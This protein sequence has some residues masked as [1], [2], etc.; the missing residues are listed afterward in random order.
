MVT[1]HQGNTESAGFSWPAI[2]TQF[3]HIN[4]AAIFVAEQTSNH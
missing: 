1:V 2:R 4:V 3:P